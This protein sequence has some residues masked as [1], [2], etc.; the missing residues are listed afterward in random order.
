MRAV[1][2]IFWTAAFAATASLSSSLPAH[3]DTIYASNV[4]SNVIYGGSATVD[5]AAELVGSMIPPCIVYG[6]DLRATSR[7]C[8]TLREGKTRAPIC[9]PRVP[10][11]PGR[12]DHEA[13]IRATRW[14]ITPETLRQVSRRA[15]SHFNATNMPITSAYSGNHPMPQCG[16]QVSLEI[17]RRDHGAVSV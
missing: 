17:L 12:D 6:P 14:P 7:V 2:R 11:V 10:R 5:G 16:W 3:A 1:G 8:T 9:Y 15:R 4:G 13:P